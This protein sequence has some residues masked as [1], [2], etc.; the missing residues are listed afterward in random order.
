MKFK[1]EKNF[2]FFFLLFSMHNKLQKKN[3]I[4]KITVLI[5]IFSTNFAISYAQLSLSKKICLLISKKKLVVM[6]IKPIK[7]GFF[8]H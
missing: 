3:W 8:L 5:I 1:N 7:K 6:K 4:E 2:F